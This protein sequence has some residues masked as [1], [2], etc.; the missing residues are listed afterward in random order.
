MYLKHQKYSMQNNGPWD[1]CVIT[2]ICLYYMIIVTGVNIDW[3]GTSFSYYT[4]WQFDLH[5]ILQACLVL[6]EK[7]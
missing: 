5:H 1:C 4:F 2:P 7:S 3:G 6:Y